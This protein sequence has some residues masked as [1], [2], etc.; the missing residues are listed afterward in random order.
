MIQGQLDFEVE[1]FG[2]GGITI[3]FNM[4]GLSLRGYDAVRFLL[5]FYLHMT[6]LVSTVNVALPS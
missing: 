5:P 2:F 4:V 1:R 6:D 3:R